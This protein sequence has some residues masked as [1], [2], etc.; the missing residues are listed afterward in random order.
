MAGWI[1]LGVIIILLRDPNNDITD[2]VYYIFTL[3]STIGP[4]SHKPT[5]PDAYVGL[6]LYTIVGLAIVNLLIGTIHERIWRSYQVDNNEHFD[7]AHPPVTLGAWLTAKTMQGKQYR[8]LEDHQ[9]PSTNNRGTQTS[10]NLALEDYD[11]RSVD[12]CSRLLAIETYQELAPN[13]F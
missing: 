5:R 6:F 13:T 4:L 12:D 7:F 9:N 10:P 1:F 3:V 2:G 11:G 8:L